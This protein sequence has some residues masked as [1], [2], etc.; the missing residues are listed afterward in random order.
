MHVSTGAGDATGSTRQRP[1]RSSGGP[2]ATATPLLAA[3]IGSNT[4]R[5]NVNNKSPGSTTD[6]RADE[7]HTRR[8][9]GGEDHEVDAVRSLTP[10]QSRGLAIRGEG[11]SRADDRQRRQHHER[12]AAA[13]GHTGKAF[14]RLTELQTSSTTAPCGGARKQHGAR[15]HIRMEHGEPITW[16]TKEGSRP[17]SDGAS[18]SSRETVGEE[19]CRTDA[20]GRTGPGVLDARSRTRPTGPTPIGISGHH[21]APGTRRDGQ[22][23]EADTERS[24][25]ARLPKCCTR[26]RRTVS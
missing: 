2:P 3:T 13:A 18:R 15:E 14:T 22:Q 19:P 26:A 21:A 20:I 23:L 6:L 9:G 4:L 8:L 7:G 25:R 1:T 5:R 12:A 10:L 24:V 16:P 17:E 11:A